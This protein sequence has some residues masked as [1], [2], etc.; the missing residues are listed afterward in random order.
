MRLAQIHLLEQDKASAEQVLQP[1]LALN[2]KE[3]KLEKELKTL[4]KQL[5]KLKS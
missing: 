1:V 2:D 5:N 3:E 4:Q